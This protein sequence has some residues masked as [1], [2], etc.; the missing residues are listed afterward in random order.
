VEYDEVIH[1]SFSA[2]QES[3]RFRSAVLC[4][5]CAARFTRMVALRTIGCRLANAGFLVLVLARWFSGM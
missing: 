1:P 3:R 5:P 2:A 4:L